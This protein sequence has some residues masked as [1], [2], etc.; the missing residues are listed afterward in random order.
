[1]NGY[2]V[3]PSKS[4]PFECSCDPALSHVCKMLIR[5]QKRCQ[6]ISLLS[7]SIVIEQAREA[8]LFSAFTVLTLIVSLTSRIQK[9]DKSLSFSSVSRSAR[10][11]SNFDARK[12]I[13]PRNSFIYVHGCTCVI[14]T[15]SSRIQYKTLE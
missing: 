3:T 13:N 5:N 11:I 14:R 10:Q 4:F 6:A 8:K 15:K 12:G 7:L 1:M 2:R 9:C